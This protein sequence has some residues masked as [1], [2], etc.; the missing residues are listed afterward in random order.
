M[1]KDV[2]KER[3]REDVSAKDLGPCNRVK[4]RLRAEKREGVLT[5]KREERGDISICRRPVEKRIYST[6]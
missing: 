6:L 4:R 2:R 3:V 1:G 5:V